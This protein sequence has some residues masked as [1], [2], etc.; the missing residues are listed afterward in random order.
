MEDNQIKLGNQIIKT[1]R[2]CCGITNEHSKH[3]APVS[4]KRN[5]KFYIEMFPDV[6]K[7]KINIIQSSSIGN[8][9]RVLLV[10]KELANLPF[11]NKL[12]QG[13]DFESYEE[14]EKVVLSKYIN[15]EIWILNDLFPKIKT[16]LVYLQR[17]KTEP[18]VIYIHEELSNEF[19]I[20]LKTYIFKDLRIK[21]N[22]NLEEYELGDGKSN[23]KSKYVCIDEK[24]ESTY[25]FAS[26]TRI[27]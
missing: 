11:Q 25:R 5:N 15:P 10:T 21:K 12:V 17:I 19:L 14:A 2:F 9:V 27:F 1:V 8:V 22:Y 7:N 20:S 13:V 23:G 24:Y 18:K 16:E 3:E 6:L 26:A 4:M